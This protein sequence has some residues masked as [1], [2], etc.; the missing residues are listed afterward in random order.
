MTEQIV[1]LLRDVMKVD[2]QVNE[3][4]EMAVE[5]IQDIFKEND[6]SRFKNWAKQA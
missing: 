5:K 4:K 3:M 2:S 6:P 1:K